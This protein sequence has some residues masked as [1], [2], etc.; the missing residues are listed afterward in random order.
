MPGRSGLEALQQMV[1]TLRGFVD[2]QRENAH[3]HDLGMIDQQIDAA[4][5]PGVYGD[6]AHSINALVQAHIAVKMQVVEVVKRYAVGDLSVDMARLPGQK[7][8][9]TAAMDSVKGNLQRVNAQIQTLVDAAA[10]GDFTA[11][12]DAEAFDHAFRAMILSLNRLMD[13]AD[14]GLG[15]VS[16]LLGALAQGDLTQRITREYRGTFAGVREGVQRTGLSRRHGPSG[17][18]AMLVLVLVLAP[19]RVRANPPAP[20][21]PKAPARASWLLPPWDRAWMAERKLGDRATY[22][23]GAGITVRS[24]DGRFS[25]NFTLWAQLLLSEKHDE[26]AAAGMKEWSTTLEL[27][28]ARAIA[29]EVGLQH[30]YVGNVH[31]REG[32]A[33]SCASCGEL[34]IVRDWY[35]I[36]RYDLTPEGHCPHCQTA[37]AGRFGKTLGHDGR[38]F[39]P[40]RIPVHL[41][42]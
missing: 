41:G 25:L 31:D 37:I 38:A 34:L 14:T 12:G 22:K 23:P 35:D 33:T 18:L 4:R 32:A 28:R 26:I 29:R 30:V 9:I 11:R 10:S 24:Q 27:R 6:M 39:G 17:L 40:R 7:A 36:R 19:G 20:T 2:A 16:R 8:Q 1:G 13:V 3:Q 21:P 42:A 15:D 5:F